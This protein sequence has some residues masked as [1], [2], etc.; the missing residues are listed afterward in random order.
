MAHVQTILEERAF[1]LRTLSLMRSMRDC[2]PD[3]QW[4]DGP[5]EIFDAIREEKPEVDDPI[6]TEFADDLRTNMG[7]WV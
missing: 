7:Y 5:E 1:V 4:E 3:G 2:L 6:W